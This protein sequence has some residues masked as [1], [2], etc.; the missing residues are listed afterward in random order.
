MATSVTAAA[1][2]RPAVKAWITA[3]RRSRSFTAAS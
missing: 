3:N 2:K 1:A